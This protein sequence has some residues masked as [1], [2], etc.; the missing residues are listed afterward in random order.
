VGRPLQAEAGEATAPSIKETGGSNDPLEARIGQTEV[1]FHPDS[2]SIGSIRLAGEEIIRGDVEANLWRAPTD[3]DGVAQGWM[4]EIHG[5]RQLWL[6]WGLDSLI[7]DRRPP[8]V[9]V[10]DRSIEIVTETTLWGTGRSAAAQHRRSILITPLGIR[11]GHRVTVPSEWSDIPRVGVRFEVPKRLGTLTWFGPGPDETYPDRR[12]GALH[13]RW[14]STVVEQY[15]PFVVPQEHGS[16]V[17]VNWFSLEDERGLGFR[18]DGTAPG[19]GARFQ[20]TVN[21]ESTLCFSARRH[22]DRDLTAATTVAELERRDTVE[23]NLG[24]AIRGLGT[25]ACGPDVLP[26]YVVGP[27]VYDFGWLIRPLTKGS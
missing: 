12:S 23:V 15:H 20:P 19:G 24:P 27:G 22:H 4:G 6:A 1:V 16:H 26:P 7:T 13:G 5:V 10:G 17:G 11:F 25:A 9:T 21:A 2:G 3:N 18:I 8:N 14:R